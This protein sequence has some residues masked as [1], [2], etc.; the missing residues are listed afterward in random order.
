MIKK[1]TKVGNSLALILDKAMLKHLGVS[2]GDSVELT[3]GS[4][5]SIIITAMWKTIPHDKATN[6][7]HRLADEYDDVMR[8]LAE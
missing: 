1:L 4:D 8:K 6:A 5:Q 2:E 3:Y 7:M